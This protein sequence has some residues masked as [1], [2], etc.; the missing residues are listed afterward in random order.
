M[1]GET[2]LNASLAARVVVTRPLVYSVDYKQVNLF[3]ILIN[4]KEKFYMKIYKIKLYYGDA[5]L[6]ALH[7]L[8]Y[9]I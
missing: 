3:F 6:H 2:A 4:I 8:K 9:G 1:Y 7:S 5:S